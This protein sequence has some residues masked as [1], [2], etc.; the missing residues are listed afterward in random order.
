MV[1]RLKELK[2]ELEEKYDKDEFI[3]SLQQA[4]RLVDLW[5]GKNKEEDKAK[6]ELWVERRRLEKIV[7][8]K[9]Q[10][11]CDKKKLEEYEEEYK[12]YI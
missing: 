10:L 5:K 8:M 7:E 1:F 11:D 12:R 9:H 6:H 2:E 3:A 4:M